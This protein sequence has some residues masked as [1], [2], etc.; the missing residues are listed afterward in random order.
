VSQGAPFTPRR[1]RG[2]LSNREGRFERTRVEVG[3]DIEPDPDVDPLADPPPLA[4]TV[5][6]ERTRSILTT[7]ES[8]DV[9]FEQSINPYRGCEHGCVYCF[10]RPTHAYLGLSPGLDFETKIFSKPDAATLL[11]R[12]LERPGYACRVTALGANTDAYQPIEKKLRITRGILEVLSEYRHPVLI[13]TKSDLVRRDLDLLGPMGRER[14]AAVMVSVTTL[15]R[16][17][18]RRMEPRAATPELRLET[19]RRLTGE[20]VPVGVLAA[21]MI[22]GLND[23]ELEAI[24]AAAAEAGAVT[25]GYVLLRLP[26]EIKDLFREWLTTHYPLKADRVEALLRDMR[27]GKLYESA[28]GTRMRGRGPH[29]DLLEQRFQVAIRR[30]GLRE[31]DFDLDASSFRVPPRPGSQGTLF[32][33]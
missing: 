10:A 7:N 1:G 33:R 12:E 28:F 4:T 31:R 19:I 15:D 14:R 26:L 18:A 16:R 29:A 3:P 21:P 30:A 32:P 13:I 8:P 22:P 25:A 11:R 9:G 24:V 23:S 5:T 27:G 20:G 17:L 6:P 2:A